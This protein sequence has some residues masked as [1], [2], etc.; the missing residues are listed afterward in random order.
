MDQRAAVARVLAR[1]EQQLAQGQYSAAIDTAERGLRLD[2]Y[3][4]DLYRVLAQAY[5]GMGGL[6]QAR[7]FARLGLR[8]VGSNTALRN[9]LE[10]LAR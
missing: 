5:A 10:L 2:R 7:N 6:E 4:A 1:A 9:Q 3:A 8:Y